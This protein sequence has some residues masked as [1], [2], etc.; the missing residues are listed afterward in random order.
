MSTQKKIALRKKIVA[1]AEIAVYI[2]IY[3]A[4]IQQRYGRDMV[5]I[6]SNQT[7]LY[8]EVNSENPNFDILA[9]GV[10]K[11]KSRYVVLSHEADNE[12]AMEGFNFEKI[13]ESPSYDVYFNL[14]YRKKEK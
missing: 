9:E 13:Y 12:A 1:P 11:A 7:K 8:K 2:R 6:P 10:R 4:T 3:D 14:R 5:N